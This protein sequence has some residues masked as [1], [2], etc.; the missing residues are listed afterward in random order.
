MCPR[1]RSPRPTRRTRAR[2]TSRIPRWSRTRATRARWRDEAEHGHARAPRS[3]RRARRW[4]S[5]RRARAPRRSRA[6]HTRATGPSSA[7]VGGPQTTS[8]RRTSWWQCASAA[9]RSGGMLD[10]GIAL[11]SPVV[12][13]EKRM[14]VGSDAWR[15]TGLN[16]ATASAVARARKSAHTRSPSR[17][18]ALSDVR[19]GRSCREQHDRRRCA[20]G[21][22]DA[23]TAAATCRRAYDV[24][25]ECELGL[26][27][28][29]AGGDLGRR[30][31]VRDGHRRHSRSDHAEECH[32]RLHVHRHVDGDR[33]AFLEA[34][35]LQRG[36]EGVCARLE[37]G[38]A[39]CAQR[40]ALRVALVLPDDGRRALVAPLQ[41]ARRHVETRPWQPL[42]ALDAALARR[43]AEHGLGGRA[44]GEAHAHA[45]EQQRGQKVSG[46]RT[47]SAWNAWS[48][49]GSP[50][51]SSRH[52]RRRR[53]RAGAAR[54]VRAAPRRRPAAVA[55]LP[56]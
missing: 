15:S 19:R 3:G 20:A 48:R 6:T 1:R 29:E 13:L 46:S 40:R 26:R 49:T 42:G 16:A 53:T 28:S 11:G 18:G 4:A 30:E 43:Y 35:R 55:A 47:L 54:L 38:P 44:L 31:R 22:R 51:R 9:L 34:A 14:P 50:V 5:R 45:R 2:S 32:H 23:R 41:A 39:D 33:V 52:W 37:A 21:R 17:S 8:P 24:L 25:R 10:Q 56:S 27:Q 12:P 7:R 36:G